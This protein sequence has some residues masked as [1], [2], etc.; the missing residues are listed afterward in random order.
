MAQELSLYISL[1]KTLK[2]IELFL[3]HISEVW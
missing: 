1:E 3:K 2:Y